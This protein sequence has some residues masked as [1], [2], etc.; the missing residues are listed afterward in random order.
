MVITAIPSFLLSNLLRPFDVP[1][2]RQLDEIYYPPVTEI[3]LGYRKADV[4][5]SLDG[6]GFLVPAKEKRKILGTIW[7]SSLFPN[8]APEGH[9]AL[10]TFVGGSRQPEMADVHDDELKKI[11]AEELQSLLRTNAPPVYS[12]IRRWKKAIP[13][14]R[15]G[16]LAL[17][18]KIEE[19]EQ[20]HPGFFISGNFRGGI[21]VG[22]CVASSEKTAERVKEFLQS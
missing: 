6:F 9:V 2:S 18:E 13:Q 22:D 3:F 20:R 4:G 15:I 14:Y 21:A 11:V 12:K 7:S 10:T 19:F 16:H 1:L 5:R 17:V 8:R